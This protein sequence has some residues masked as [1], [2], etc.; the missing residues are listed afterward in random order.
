MRKFLMST[1][2]YPVMNLVINLYKQAEARNTDEYSQ[3]AKEQVALR[4][5]MIFRGR[6][7]QPMFS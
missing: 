7:F 1:P 6:P 3:F 2:S 4:Y 5:K